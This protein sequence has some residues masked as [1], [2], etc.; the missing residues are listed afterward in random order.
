MQEA[1]FHSR[2]THEWNLEINR[3]DRGPYFI[4]GR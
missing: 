2:C 1:H 3:D 4:G